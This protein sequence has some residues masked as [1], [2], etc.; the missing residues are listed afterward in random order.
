MAPKMLSPLLLCLHK[1]L[2]ILLTV[3]FSLVDPHP[4]LSSSSADPI[5]DDTWLLKAALTYL[6]PAQ[7]LEAR[8]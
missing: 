7:V 3:L 1:S 4:P 8:A 5:L 6:S 2:H